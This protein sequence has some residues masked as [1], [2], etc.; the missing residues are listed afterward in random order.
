MYAPSLV[1]ADLAA[2]PAVEICDGDGG[3]GHDRLAGIGDD[4]SDARRLANATAAPSSMR[5]K[6]SAVFMGSVSIFL[7]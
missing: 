5:K 2:Q 4:P 1:G 6:S 7:A 3:A